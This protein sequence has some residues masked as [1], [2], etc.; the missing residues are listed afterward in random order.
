MALWQ[1]MHL[2][3][4]DS[5]ASVTFLWKPSL[6]LKISKAKAALP[7]RTAQYCCV[8]FEDADPIQSKTYQE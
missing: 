8:D 6:P 2:G 3:M 5:H 4:L 7:T 1:L